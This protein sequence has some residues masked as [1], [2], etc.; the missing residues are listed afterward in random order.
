MRHPP[1]GRA[2]VRRGH[3]LPVVLTIVVAVAVAV[4]LGLGGYLLAHT[5]W[6]AAVATV[7][8]AV[9]LVKLLAIIF[10]RKVIRRRGA[11]P[12][13]PRRAP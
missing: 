3:R 9:V 10:G 8:V 13:P 12:A 4:H 1:T 5:R 7:V 6:T 11:T 2:G